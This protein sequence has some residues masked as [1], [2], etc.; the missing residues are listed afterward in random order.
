MKLRFIAVFICI[1]CVLRSQV[2][3]KTDSIID[4]AS[5][6]VGVKYKYASSSPQK[7]FD[8]SGFVNFVFSQFGVQVPRSSKLFEHFGIAV[9]LD[10]CKKGDVL[11]FNKP[12]HVAIVTYHTKD[13]LRFIH[14]SSDKRHGGV[15]VSEFNSFSNYKKRFV[16]AIRIPSM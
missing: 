7:G 15:K 16:K 4:F 12:G 8:C 11:L 14:A 9:L 3:T 10:S 1:S 5:K 6:H 2:Y 13:S